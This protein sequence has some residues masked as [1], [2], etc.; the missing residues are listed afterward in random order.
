LNRIT[1]VKSIA[2]ILHAEPDLEDDQRRRFSEII[3]T[4]S[5]LLGSSARDMIE[6]L[7]QGSDA[8]KPATP[9]NEVDDFIIANGNHFPDLEEAADAV[10]TAAGLSGADTDFRLSQRL[11]DRHGVAV[12]V[13]PP[14]AAQEQGDTIVL[15]GPAPAATRRFHLARALAAREMDAAIATAMRGARLSSE[16]ARATVRRALENYAAGALLAPYD[17]FLEA[18]ERH[19]YDIDHLGFQFS[20]SFEQTAHRM[21]TLRKLGAEG[22]PFAFVR[23]DPAGNLSKPFS[24]TGLRMPRLGGACPLWVLYGV[25]STPERTVANWRRCP[26][27]N[28]TFSSPAAWRNGWRRSARRNQ[29]TASC[30]AAT[31]STPTASFTATASSTAARR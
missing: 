19:R 21:V 3:S 10:R 20:L 8:P 9:R 6:T 13:G 11:Q 14:G 24:T 30:W 17:A 5:D 23:A 16:A 31:P 25:F 1:A 28:A 12:V 2:S 7:G 4:E 26:R 18:A 15:D 27:A 29:S 22:V